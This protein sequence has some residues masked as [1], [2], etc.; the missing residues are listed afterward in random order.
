MVISNDN[1]RKNEANHPD[2][3]QR[4]A[5]DLAAD[6]IMAR[7]EQRKL[8]AQAWLDKAKVSIDANDLDT[9]INQIN[10]AKK[11]YPEGFVPSWYPAWLSVITKT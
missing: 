5:N 10:Q 1:W 3:H 6:A 11:E 4:R 2:Q 7:T 9:A 8:N